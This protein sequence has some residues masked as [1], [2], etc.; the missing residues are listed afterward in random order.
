MT[1]RSPWDGS[2]RVVHVRSLLVLLAVTAPST[3]VYA[4]EEVLLDRCDDVSRWGLDPGY[5]FPGARGAISTA[6]DGNDGKC[7]R[8]DYDFTGGGNYVTAAFPLSGFAEASAVVFSVRQEGDNAG[9]VRVRDAT[10]QE[11]AGA[12][13]AG[14]EW[15]RVVVPLDR[16]HFAGFWHG[17]NDGQFYFPLNRILIGASRGPTPKG[18]LFIKDLAVITDDAASFCGATV[19]T[20]DPGNVAFCGTKDALVT[21]TVAN[22]LARAVRLGLRGRVRG[23]H[24][25]LREFA[26]TEREMAGHHSTAHVLRLEAQRPGYYVVE[27]EV[28]QRGQPV[29]AMQGALVVSPRPLNFG[30]DD[31]QSF[32]GMQHTSDGARL[33]RLG[34][35]WVRAGRDWRWGELI[36]DH[37][38]VPDLADLRRNHQLVMFTMTA[39]PPQWALER[40]HEATFWEAPG[41]E[42]RMGWWGDY[43]TH[44]AREL[45][46]RVDTFE[47]QNEPDL[48]C[49]YQVGL[50]FP[51]GVSRYVRILQAGSR[52]VREAAPGARVAG[53]DVSG[54]DYDQGLPYS[55][56]VMAQAGAAIDVY[57]GHPYAGVRYFGAGQS[58][59]WPGPNDERRK[60][61]DT[62]RMIR[63]FGGGQRFWVGEKGWGLDI[64]ADPLSDFSRDFA[65]CLVQS[66]VLAHSVPGVER[67][68]WFLEEGCNEQGYE[69]GLFRQGMPLP[70]AL[71]YATLAQMLHHAAP[72]RSPDLDDMVQAHC[73]TSAETGQGT[74]VLWSEGQRASVAFPRLPAAVEQVE[75][76]GRTVSW[77]RA[78]DSLTVD[79][80]REPV[81]L[82]FPAGAARAMCRAVAAAEI[83]NE[84]PL[85]LEAAYAADLTHLGAR[86]RNVTAAACSGELAYPDGKVTVEVPG[87][88]TMAVLLP[89]TSD[90][91][92]RP[93]EELAVSLHVRT[94]VQRIVV[95][96]TLAPLAAIPPDAPRVPGTPLPD[97]QW[98]E[99][100]SPM[101]LDSRAQVYPPD[102]T[103]GWSTPADLSAR[104]WVGWDE[105]FLHLAA[106]V[107]D[108]VPHVASDDPAYFWQSDSLQLALDPLN[109]AG[110]APGFLADDRE[111]G[112]VLGPSGGRAV[113]TVPEGRVLDAPCRVTREG[114]ETHYQVAI[115]WGLIG[116]SPVAG[117]VIGLSFIINQNNGQ[118][119]AYWMGLTP[120]I[121]EAKRPVAY[122]DF[123]LAP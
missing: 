107:R 14:A 11:H 88:Q 25:E 39:Y 59:L 119:R 56:A 43:V 60:C 47:I 80:E 105:Q 33:E 85:V 111:F 9:F 112:L 10:E 94:S 92:S 103:V 2:E 65:R 90:L 50:D 38:Q 48:T 30:V 7:L 101:V 21:V 72:Y 52:A 114:Q 77:L 82:R 64:T 44:M 22:R 19:S 37:Y 35:K 73:F 34:C 76:M 99:Q 106:V 53:I 95:R 91:S 41:Y 97:L 83:A 23:W 118:G 36:E 40:A 63:D 123:C 8:L 32:F 116:V 71:A 102:P 100:R 122:R 58:T 6:V 3:L 26:F 75:M 54:G 1:N 79:L 16:E 49:M 20:P 67:Y 121:G 86:L 81:Y 28:L 70:A 4:S 31:P 42:E 55:R 24:G 45:A 104:V 68:F 93:S 15:T 61:Q 69:Y 5:E 113:Q 27:A 46:P 120:G 12:Y 51:A 66:M 108:P 78:G 57:T 74:M 87:G 96:P 98:W 84:Q 89:V 117:R 13:S 110:E 29:T 17:R 115:P 109:D 18:A 62:L